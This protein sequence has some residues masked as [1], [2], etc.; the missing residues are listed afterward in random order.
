MFPLIEVL[1]AFTIR[2]YNNVIDAIYM[3][4][5]N[6]LS[7]SAAWSIN[8][9]EGEESL[10]CINCFWTCTCLNASSIH[11]AYRLRCHRPGTWRAY[12]SQPLGLLDM[13]ICL[14]S[15]KHT[16]QTHPLITYLTF[17]FHATRYPIRM[18]APYSFVDV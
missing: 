6:S 8:S 4:T 14:R 7:I 12:C 13:S 10:A 16:T 1:I 3:E 5:I 9:V 11:L 17:L 15:I 2:S 18:K